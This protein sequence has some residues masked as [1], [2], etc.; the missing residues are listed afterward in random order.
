MHVLSLNWNY[1]MCS[2][3]YI[4][5][6]EKSLRRGAWDGLREGIDR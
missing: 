3:R 2:A 6:I 5:Y 1:G 4:R